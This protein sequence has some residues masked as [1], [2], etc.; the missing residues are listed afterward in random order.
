MEKVPLR[1][2]WGSSRSHLIWL[3]AMQKTTTA[4]ASSTCSFLRRFVIPA[5]RR[6]HSLPDSHNDEYFEYGMQPLGAAQMLADSGA[7]NRL[8]GRSSFERVKRRHHRLACVRQSDSRAG[9]HA[10]TP[11]SMIDTG[12]TLPR[13]AAGGTSTPQALHSD[14]IQTLEVVLFRTDAC[15][16]WTALSHAWTRMTGHAV[17]ASLGVPAKQFVHVSDLVRF[18]ALVQNML[19]NP[20]QFFRQTLRV[21]RAGGPSG[22]IDVYAAMQTDTLGVP[23]ASCG[24]L[25]DAIPVHPQRMR[26]RAMRVVQDEHH[27]AIDRLGLTAALTATAARQPLKILLVEDQPVTQKLMRLVLEKWGH[28]VHLASD[29]RAG[30]ECFL[31]S[32]FDLVL[33]DLQLPVMD[34]L[35]VTMAIREFESQAGLARTP[36]IAL[37]AQ[38]EPGDR[39]I[40]F[41]AGMDDYLAKPVKAPV[42]REILQSYGVQRVQHP[43]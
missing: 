2:C 20:G 26:G 13:R 9:R 16:Q 11:F 39:E 41:A 42:L 40:C 12:S 28:H 37:T 6:E 35:S 10:R 1:V 23:I 29:G 17:S 7:D 5:C 18:A 27:G 31:Q 32:A 15:G 33:M 21:C 4:Y 19:Q 25:A 43:A 30:L 22:L 8:S 14:L 38:T 36:V 3:R 24:Y 34:G